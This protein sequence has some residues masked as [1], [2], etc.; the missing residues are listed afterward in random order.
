MAVLVTADIPGQTA[1]GYDGLLAALNEA[2]RQSKGFIAHFAMP[3]S[4]GW[5]CMELW[6]TQQD[7][8]EFFARHVHPML[9]P[10]IK[11]KRSFVPLH[12]LVQPPAEVA[13][14]VAPK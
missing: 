10:G 7:A 13:A 11:P 14:G 12:A 5:T 2:M 4:N 1:A 6:D 8:N 3:A 9:P